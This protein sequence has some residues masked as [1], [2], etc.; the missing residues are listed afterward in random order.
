MAGLV[1]PSK[2]SGYI[3]FGLPI[4]YLGPADTNSAEVCTRFHGG[5]WIPEDG[6]GEEIAAVAAALADPHRLASAATGA[7]VAAANLAEL[8]GDSLA[9]LLVP[10]LQSLCGMAPI[11]PVPVNKGQAA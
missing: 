4:V 11:A 1:S 3:N 10:R 9:E 2:F 7:R 6:S 5:F 8:N